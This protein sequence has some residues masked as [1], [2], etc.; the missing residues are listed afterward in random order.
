M[1][2]F[3]EKAGLEIRGLSYQKSAS[4]VKLR[5]LG[6]GDS[7]SRDTERV[8]EVAEGVG[9]TNGCGVP[10]QHPRDVGEYRE[11]SRKDGKRSERKHP[12]MT[13]STTEHRLR[14]LRNG[15]GREGSTIG[16]T[17]GGP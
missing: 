15:E 12:W 13:G 3:P 9:S 8:S 16:S 14:R 7:D 1:D 4:R 2:P 11:H 5:M 17:H 6:K 10:G